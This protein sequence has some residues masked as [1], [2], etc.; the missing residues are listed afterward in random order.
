MDR[1]TPQPA[2]DRIL[3]SALLPLRLYVSNLFHPSAGRPATGAARPLFD[4]AIFVLDTVAGAKEEGF[5]EKYVQREQRYI[6]S[7]P[8]LYLS[9]LLNAL[10]TGSEGSTNIAIYQ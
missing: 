7:L 9:V 10:V 4:F 3:W 8:L 1:Q 2:T 6:L 5:G